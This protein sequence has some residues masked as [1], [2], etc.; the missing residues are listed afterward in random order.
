MEFQGGGGCLSC[1]PTCSPQAGPR[2]SAQQEPPLPSREGL[3][4]S[5]TWW[6]ALGEGLILPCSIPGPNWHQH[7]GRAAS[8]PRAS[9]TLK[10]NQGRT[11]LK[12]NPGDV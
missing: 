9:V 6:G 8:Q 2:L 7:L 1:Q 11:W 4:N 12:N 5:G 10:I 3:V